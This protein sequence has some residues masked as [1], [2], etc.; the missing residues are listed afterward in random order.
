MLVSRTG[1][2][3]M[4]ETMMKRGAR[5]PSA[6]EGQYFW[7][8]RIDVTSASAGTSMKAASMEPITG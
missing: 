6:V 5:A 2:G 4:F 1:S 7:W 8:L 3:V